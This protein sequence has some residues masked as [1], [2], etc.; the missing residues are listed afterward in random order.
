[1]KYFIY[2]I[3]PLF[4]FLNTS[5]AVDIQIKYKINNE[6][7]TNQD[8]VNEIN[9][10]IAMNKNLSDLS[11]EQVKSFAI[12]SVIQEK[13][14]LIELRKSFDLENLGD[15]ANNVISRNIFLR[16]N[17]QNKDQLIKYISDFGIKIEEIETKFKI[18]LLWNKLIYDKF[19]E[20]VYINRDELKNKINKNLQ[21]KKDIYEYN[22]REILFEISEKEDLDSKLKK[23]K[24]TIKSTSFGTAATIYS[25][26]NTSDKKGEI[27]WVKETQLS[28][29]VLKKIKTLKLNEFTEPF[30]AGNGYLILELNNIR[31]I[32]EKI[33]VDK[34]LEIL[35]EKEIDRQLNQYS[36][37][38][39]NKI[40]KNVLINEV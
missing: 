9:Y 40:K 33:D 14:K 10:L 38:Y 6:I 22:I 7:I 30:I 5:N 11:R 28:R 32:E 31:K 29:E 21:N 24:D 34:E 23:I 4:F 1:M 18:E 39:F 16:T 25:I 20:K 13:I 8:I 27:G 12:N 3:F 2:I 26:S 35:V 37:I 19:Y 36:T 15:N 17:T